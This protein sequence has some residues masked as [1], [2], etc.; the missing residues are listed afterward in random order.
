MSLDKLLVTFV[1]LVF[2]IFPQYLARANEPIKI[3]LVPGHDNE[4]WGAQYGNVK[5]GAMNLAVA[6]RIFKLLKKDKRF[7]V[8]I[9]RNLEGYTKTFADYFSLYQDEILDFIEKSKKETQG[10][11]NNGEFIVKENVPHNTASEDMAMR[12]YG[13]NKWANENKM[14]VIIHIHFNDYPRESK[15]T[16]GKY[17]GFVIYIPDEQMVNWKESGQLATNIYVELDKKYS[18]STYEKE[19]GGLIPDQKLI[20]L[21]SNSTLFPDVRSVLIEY[22]YIYEKKFRNYTTRHKAYDDMAKLTV[23]GISNYFFKK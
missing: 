8:Y 1:F 14:D 10:K 21:G 5:E 23:T 3:L 22:G 19:L 4:V 16:I 11:I 13:L 12:L 2:F 20:A 18:T 6:S 17:G 15:W 7:D 9:T